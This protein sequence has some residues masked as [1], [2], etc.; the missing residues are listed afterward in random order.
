MPM[1]LTLIVTEKCF[2]ALLPNGL[3]L[4]SA[5]RLDDLV[6]HVVPKNCVLTLHDTGWAYHETQRVKAYFAQPHPRIRGVQIVV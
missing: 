5:I 1:Q 6:K 3:L 4:G 2:K